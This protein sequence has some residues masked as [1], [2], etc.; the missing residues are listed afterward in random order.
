[1]ADGSINSAYYPNLWFELDTRASR[2]K[3]ETRRRSTAC[4]LSKSDAV[5]AR[6]GRRNHAQVFR[7]STT[8]R[9]SIGERAEFTG[10]L[11][12]DDSVVV[13]W[14]LAE[15]LA[16]SIPG[17]HS[18]LRHLAGLLGNGAT[19]AR[20]LQRRA[21]ARWRPNSARTA[22]GSASMAIEVT[23]SGTAGSA[24]SRGKTARG[25]ARVWRHR[26]QRPRIPRRHAHRSSRWHRVQRCQSHRRHPPGR[27][28]NSSPYPTAVTSAANNGPPTPSTSSPPWTPPTTATTNSSS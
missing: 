24:P 23:T 1:M 3:A 11:T 12:T 8:P 13:S 19:R 10:A 21:G 9:F 16:G 26:L 5:R 20:R 28:A 7:A 14:S 22:I 4:L 17:L 15:D 18:S 25:G 6:D 27:L 2:G